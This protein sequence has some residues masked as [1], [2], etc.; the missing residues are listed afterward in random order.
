MGPARLPVGNGNGKGNGNRGGLQEQREASSVA[1]D[2]NG[3]RSDWARVAVNTV[4]MEKRGLLCYGKVTLYL[5]KL[6]NYKLNC[7]PL[8]FIND[9]DFGGAGSVRSGF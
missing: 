6:Y 4:F 7:F 9:L 1:H 3:L 8:Y 5:G 2:G